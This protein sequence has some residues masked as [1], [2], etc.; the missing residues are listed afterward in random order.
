MKGKNDIF[1]CRQ[2]CGLWKRQ[3]DFISLQNSQFS[4]FVNQLSTL[5]QQKIL[6]SNINMHILD[7]RQFCGLWKRQ[8]DFISLQNSQF[9]H[10]DNQLFNSASTDTNHTE[11]KTSPYWV[12]NLN[13]LGTGDAD[14]RIYITTVQD[15][16]HKSVFLTRAWFP[17]TIHLITQK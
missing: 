8:P 6:N 2:F 10:F 15:G 16:W 13:T 17:R 12:D 9:S 7:S 5:G 3:S 11:H 1:D 14:L 4:H